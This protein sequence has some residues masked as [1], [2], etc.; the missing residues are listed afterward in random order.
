MS[1]AGVALLALLAAL[2]VSDGRPIADPA[3]VPVRDPGAEQTQAR[4]RI[5]SYLAGQN[6]LLS[7]RA[8]ERIV[9]SVLRCDETY[10]LDPYLVA[11]VLDTESTARPWVVSPKGAVGLM[12]VM[13]HMYGLFDLAG[14][15]T[16]I[17]SN[18]EAGCAIL[19]DN[20]RRLGENDGILAYF[21]GTN[22]RGVSYLHRVREARAALREP[23]ES[24]S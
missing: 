3:R 17:E 4:L 14:N 21:W 11:G 9:D 24:R 15:I 2:L 12:Q 8:L 5:E 23:P 6:P 10:G 13:P 16:T 1:R 20:I 19:S 22:I 18:I 7:E